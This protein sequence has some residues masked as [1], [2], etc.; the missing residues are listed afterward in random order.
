MNLNKFSISLGLYLS[1]EQALNA[2]GRAIRVAQ[3]WFG[4]YF[5]IVATWQ[6]VPQPELSNCQT[7]KK[8]SRVAGYIVEGGGEQ[9]MQL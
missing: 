9:L 4:D 2:I 8:S 5:L 6:D 3:R 1:L 7:N